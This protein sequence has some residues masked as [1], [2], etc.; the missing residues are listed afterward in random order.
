MYNS[1]DGK[2][3]VKKAKKVFSEITIPK[4]RN[5][6]MMYLAD[7][8]R[9]EKWNSLL[10]AIYKIKHGDGYEENSFNIVYPSI[11]DSRWNKS[12]IIAPYYLFS[13][14]IFAHYTK[15]QN[16][17]GM[18]LTIEVKIIFAFEPITA[19]SLH[20][21]L[22]MINELQ[23]EAQGQR[24]VEVHI[25]FYPE[26]EKEK[27]EL[28]LSFYNIFKDKEKIKYYIMENDKLAL[29]SCY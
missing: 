28:E 4:R 7:N 26:S 22:S 12:N 27:D 13:D 6:I 16:I 17:A 15:K 20:Y 21:I 8:S 29:T 25:Y 11:C 23:I 9:I 3:D 2:Y 10:K 14:F 24:G 5:P 1:S 19:A 18:I